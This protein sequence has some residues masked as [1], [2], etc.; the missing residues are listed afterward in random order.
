[1]R[2]IGTA[3]HV[4]HGKSTLV[5][6]L[7]GIHPDRLK[8]EREREMTIDLGFAWLTLP[9]GES[10]G[11]VDVPGHRDFIEN[12]LA[13]VGGIDAA[14]FVVA[15]DEGVMPQ[16]REHLAILDLLQI[17]GGVVAL[18]KA[19]LA[20]S[21]DWLALVSDE[22][23]QLLEGTALAAAPIVPVSARSGQ[24]LDDLRRALQ[25]CLA[26]RPAR[27]DLARPRLPIDRIFTIA[28]FGTVITG[29]LAD[30]ALSA[31]DEVIILPG[32]H[33]AR[34]RG[35][36]THK[37]KIER[38]LPGSRVAVNLTGVQLSDIR[39][40]DV[41]CHPNTLR[42]T[43]LVDAQFRHLDDAD[44][45]LKHNAEVKFF[46]GAAETVA[47]ARVLGGEAVPPGAIGWLQLAFNDPV[48]V[49]KG[50]RF[51]LRRPSPGATI[52]GGLIVDPH[53]ARRHKRNDPA[54]LTRLE[55]NLRGTPGEILLQ[56]MNTLGPGPLS[57]S[58]AKSGLDSAAASDAA[59]DL[60]AQGQLIILDSGLS[61]P[62]LPAAT[63]IASRIALHRLTQTTTDLLAAHHKAQPLK[64][65][66]PR[67][68]LKSKLKLAPKVFNAFVSWMAGRGAVAEA[69]AL[70][71]LPSHE[72]KLS[73]DQQASADRLFTVFRRDP[74]NTPSPK[75]ASAM[76]GDDVLGVLL[77]RGD[78]IAVSTDVYFLRETYEKMAADI[79]AYLA[80]NRTI[81]VAQVRD[82]FATSRKY[83]LALM[84]H[85]DTIG[86][87]IRKG[88]ER[89]LK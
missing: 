17:N 69:G 20:E 9:D 75:D 73:A 82:M 86:V 5:H 72:V 55:T 89:V 61:A 64:A 71:R 18:T 3:G 28:G 85:L 23:S 65:G 60:F 35:L 46:V 8:E 40:G 6:A 47:T 84:E 1:M 54:T 59:A 30:G 2:V 79:R 32:D 53:P 16:T 78:L 51:I 29:T 88:D 48:V 7:T 68:E 22:I 81:T 19:D 36:Q 25:A 56:A 87:T 34:I 21:P 27:P 38:A 83:A 42:T 76:V 43:E 12:M 26:A 41:L 67:E 13:G 24:G 50:D 77:D 58:V 62:P 74:H 4:D 10:V 57:E 11:V 33:P 39:R 44:L 14:L 80:A 31:G 49:V 63:L 66:L 37:T 70:L 45:P 52:G 15:A